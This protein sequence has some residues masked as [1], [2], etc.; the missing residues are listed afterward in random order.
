M[1][2]PE[3][4]ILEALDES[5]KQESFRK[6]DMVFD[7]LASLHPNRQ[8]ALLTDCKKIKVERLFFVLAERRG[9]TPQ[10]IALLYPL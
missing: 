4:A 7:G 9:Y 1:F 2:D 3:R 6:L 8:N 10:R 5:P